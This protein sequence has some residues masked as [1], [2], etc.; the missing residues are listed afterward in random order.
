MFEKYTPKEEI[1]R[2]IERYDKEIKEMFKTTEENKEKTANHN[3]KAYGRRGF[4]KPTSKKQDQYLE[5]KSEIET[6]TGY[7]YLAINGCGDQRNKLK[8]KL[9]RYL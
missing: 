8:K 9:E 5:K 4:P 6:K 3:N 1:E 7:I 2:K